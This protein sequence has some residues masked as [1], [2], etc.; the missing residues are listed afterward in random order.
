M[1]QTW[2]YN[3]VFTDQEPIASI[4]EEIQKI[5]SNTLGR[6]G[7][8]M[9]DRIKKLAISS[10][11]LL[12]SLDSFK[13]DSTS[14]YAYFHLGNQYKWAYLKGGNVPEEALIKSGYREKLY[15]NKPINPVQV[16]QL[17]ESIIVYQENNGHPFSSVKLDSVIETNES[18]AATL[19]L[20]K[21]NYVTIDSI[22]YKGDALISDRYL[23]NY[24]NLKEG[25]PYNEKAVRQITTKIKEV[26]FITEIKP[27]EL[28]FTDKYTLLTLYL[29]KKKASKF[30]G[31][32][33]FLPNPETGD[34]LI[35][36]DIQL[37]LQ[38]ALA[39]GESIALNWRKLQDNT[40]DFKVKA[41]YPFIANTPF[42]LEGSFFLYKRD[43]TFQDI[44]PKISI[45]YILPGANY[46]SLFYES[47][48]S[49]LLSTKSLENINYIPQQLDITR[50]TYGF[51]IL[52]QRLDYRLN[53]TKGYSI[54][55]SSGVANRKIIPNSKLPDFIYD[56]LTL[57]TIQFIG[58]LDADFFI[59]IFSRSTIN[60]GLLGSTLLGPSTF[61]NELFR[62]GGLKTLRGFDEES[63]FASTYIISTIEYRFILEQNSFLHAFIDAAYYENNSLESYTNDTPFGVGLGINFETK[64]GIFSLSYALGYQQ[65]EFAPIRSAKIHFGFV[66]YF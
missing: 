10:G 45:Q 31:I 4:K 60:F 7:I 35:T 21:S 29:N 15:T 65:N 32:V 22:I 26:P 18:I 64:A 36:G 40:T 56:S 1:G 50:N 9:S 53:P 55:F 43:T 48:I 54:F 28:L 11:Y 19:H 33:G 62:I 3:A 51:E 5:T 58:Q 57:N 12:C 8:N 17:L 13:A 38:N 52:N 16:Y 61:R 41:A 59:P 6:D 14:F 47:K 44:A 20:T 23:Q 34:V 66:N 24:L 46:L 42:G 2:T 63:I 27:A 25:D 30:N 49:R 39:G 37:Q